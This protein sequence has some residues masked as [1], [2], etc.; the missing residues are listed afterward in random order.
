MSHFTKLSTKL[1]DEEFIKS[2]LARMGYEPLP[3]GKGVA[4]W[5][6]QRTQADFKISPAGARHE[7]GFARTPQGYEIV[8]D[9]YGMSI[10]R[11]HFTTKLSREYAI[12]ATKATLAR[13]GYSLAEETLTENGTVRLVLTRHTGM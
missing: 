7:I 1:M 5:Q 8:A 9:W 6:G 13:D 11:N 4:G 2:A 12:D 10:D 3:V